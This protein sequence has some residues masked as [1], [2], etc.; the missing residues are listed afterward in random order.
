MKSYDTAP[1]SRGRIRAVGILA[2]GAACLSMVFLP[3][4]RLR[5]EADHVTSR[6]EL[7]V[8]RL[9]DG[10]TIE[11]APQTAI[12]VDGRSD[13]RR[14]RLVTGQAFFQV[15]SDIA[16]PFL[17]ESAGLRATALGTEFDVRLT[18]EVVGVSVKQGIVRAEFASPASVRVLEAGDWTSVSRTGR[19]AI[20][21]DAPADI[22]AWREG[23]L[24]ARDRPLSQV[25]DELR[26]YFNGMI[27]IAGDA[28]AA[29]C[30][31]GVYA[32][33][34]P[35]ETLRAIARSDAGIRVTRVLP[36]LLV[37]SGG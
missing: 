26:P 6:G 5:L 31:N 27:V 24:V 21:R 36:W 22:A 15:K 12:E 8:V 10:S 30:V 20:G 17:V 4:L 3:G 29:R 7:R 16:R 11:L 32:L 14:V 23:R 19:V 13:R 9:A 37:V 25:V 33:R 1:I 2:I 18:E 35:L 34:D 28:A